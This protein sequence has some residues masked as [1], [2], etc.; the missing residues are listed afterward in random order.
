MPRALQGLS[1]S[2]SLHPVKRTLSETSVAMLMGRFGT[3]LLFQSSCSIKFHLCSRSEQ[4]LI[5][6]TFFLFLLILLFHFQYSLIITLTKLTK[7]VQVR[8]KEEK[9]IPENQKF[10]KT[11]KKLL[12]GSEQ[13][14]PMAPCYL[15]VQEWN[16]MLQLN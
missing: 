8:V 3:I 11:I 6:N 16:F 12:A 14:Y 13:P 2:I 1:L 9:L 7:M 10:E 5:Q 4:V 15:N